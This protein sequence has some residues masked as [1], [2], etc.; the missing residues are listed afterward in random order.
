MNINKRFLEKVF[1]ALERKQCI[2]LQQD[3]SLESPG[4]SDVYSIPEPISLDFINQC[5]PHFERLYGEK[6]KLQ[7]SD[8]SFSNSALDF[9]FKL[10]LN[11]VII[12]GNEIDK[13]GLHVHLSHII[14]VVFDG[15]GTLYYENEKGERVEAV[16]KKGDIVIVP[17][18]AMHYFTGKI[19]FSAFEFSDVIDYQK[20]HYSD[21]E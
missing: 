16:A 11:V 9:S 1:D 12:D 7:L 10:G 5:I 17:R 2:V 21:I 18:G 20:H 6:R 19:S 13:E 4:N 3:V 14:A 8:F 15:E